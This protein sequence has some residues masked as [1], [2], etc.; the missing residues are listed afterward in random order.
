MRSGHNLGKEYLWCVPHIADYWNSALPISGW[1]VSSHCH[2]SICL[3]ILE[4]YNLPVLLPD[5][6]SELL[7]Q[8][9]SLLIKRSKEWLSDWQEP[10]FNFSCCMICL[11][12]GFVRAF[13]Q[14]PLY[15]HFTKVTLIHESGGPSKYW[16]FS[17]D[18]SKYLL[19][20][21]TGWILILKTFFSFDIPGQIFQIWAIASC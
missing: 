14:W 9:C 18:F 15:C 6:A 19:S 20:R 8:W 2:V 13:G 1:T 3:N 7:I 5:T 11:S 4:I 17:F 10:E 16:M 12:E 21:S